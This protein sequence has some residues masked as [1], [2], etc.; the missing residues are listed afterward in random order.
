MPNSLTK[1]RANALKSLMFTI[2]IPD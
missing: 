2:D 1:L